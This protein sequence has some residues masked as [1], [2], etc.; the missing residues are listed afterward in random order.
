MLAT[1]A[2]NKNRGRSSLLKSRLSAYVSLCD[3]TGVQTIY[4]P[5]APS[6]GRSRWR[7]QIR[8]SATGRKLSITAP[9]KTEAE[10]LK[11]QLEQELAQASPLQ[12]HEALDQYAEYK[13]TMIRSPR[14]V[15]DLIQALKQLI[16]DGQVMGVSKAKAEEYYLAETKRP[17]K[18]GARSAATHHGRLRAAKAFWGWLVR[19]DM[20]TKNPWEAVEPVGKTKAGKKQPREGEARLLDRH[21]FEQAAAGEEDALALL[22]QLYLGLRP[23]EVL[24]LT[25]GCIEGAVVYV[26]GTKNQNAVRK[27]ELYA[28]VAE[29]LVAFC[30]GRPKSQRVFAADRV[31]QPGSGWMYKRLKKLCTKLGIEQICPHALRGLHSSLA[32]TA[33]ATSQHVAAAL[34]HASFSTTS[35]HYATRES[36]EV[37]RARNFVSAMTSEP[38]EALREALAQHG[39]NTTKQNES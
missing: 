26:N 34:G 7:V 6:R 31:T 29:L 39:G 37:G 11:G 9:T 10:K 23:S 21:L 2:A 13:A 33:G 32:L 5:Y 8:D 24:G 25:V 28:P 16:P 19:R 1:T 18:K 27:L 36:I 20:A 22:V 30:Q 14:A 4:G 35:R 12:V 15:A 17:G 38:G 3:D